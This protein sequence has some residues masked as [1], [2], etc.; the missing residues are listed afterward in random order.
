[1]TDS[2]Y[3]QLILITEEYLGPAAPRFVDRQ[4]IAHLNKRP[5]ALTADDLPKLAEWTKVTMAL[6]TSDRQ[7][8]ADYG[9]K[10]DQL[11]QEATLL[12]NGG[13]HSRE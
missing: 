13:Q 7:V 1:M 3:R 11:S 5:E 9:H 6:L 8:V 4:I 10:I 12:S 2:L